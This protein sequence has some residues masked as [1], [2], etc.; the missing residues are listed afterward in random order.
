MPELPEVETIVRELEERTVGK[1]IINIDI[2]R[3]SYLRGQ[4]PQYIRRNTQNKKIIEVIRRGKYIIFELENGRIIVHLGMTG[5]FIEANSAGDVL[6]HTIAIFRF[7]DFSLV[8]ND[9]RRFGQMRYF[10][11]DYLPDN[12]V[13]LGVEPF[14][15]ELNIKYIQDRFNN[16]KR[17]IKEVLL[18]Q[19]IIAGLGNVYASEILFKSGIHPLKSADSLKIEE[20]N[21]L[22][23]SIRL[24]LS[25]AIKHNGTTIADYRR[26]DDK[27]GQFQDFLTVYGKEGE[28]CVRCGTKVERIVIGGRSSFYCGNCQ[29]L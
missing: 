10:E 3:K 23:R 19:T 8:L 27:L 24:V 18:D 29:K 21:L 25:E 9:V 16:R 6:K 11:K 14:S 7:E 20:I 13:K 1:I 26:V 4:S 12:I 5:K 2:V 17:A 22:I 15:E 28:R